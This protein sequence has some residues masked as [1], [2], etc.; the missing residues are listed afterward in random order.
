[1]A[2]N[3]LKGKLGCAYYDDEFKEL[4]VMDDTFETPPFNVATSRKSSL[5][6][7]TEDDHFFYQ[8]Y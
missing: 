2:V 5:F 7:P 6:I 4:Y 3:W 1:M 8:C